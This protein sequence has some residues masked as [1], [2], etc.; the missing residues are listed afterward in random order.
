MQLVLRV[1]SKIN[2][3]FGGSAAW[4]DA[5]REEG[6]SPSW[7][8]DRRAT[9]QPDRRRPAPT[10]WGD[11]DFW[12]CCSSVKE[13]RLCSL[14]A[15]SQKSKSP[16]AKSEFIFEQTLNLI[17]PFLQ[18]F[19]HCFD[20]VVISG[21]LSFLTRE[22]N[23]VYFFRQVCGYP[24]LSK[25]VFSQRTKD[26]RTWVERYAARKQIPIEW[27]EG[28]VRKKD[29]L[30]PKLASFRKSGRFGVYFI[31]CSMEQ[32]MTFAIRNPKYATSDPNYRILRKQRSRFTLLLLHL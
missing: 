18:W 13:R 25:E 1:C 10:G 12:R 24:G 15:P 30:A 11:F 22:N 14:V 16:P 3:D 4:P 7:G 19:Y 20:R 29:Y 32:E 6:A 8:C 23:V 26:Y 21:Y 9:P 17:G 5:R 27:A 2:S 31:L 28:G